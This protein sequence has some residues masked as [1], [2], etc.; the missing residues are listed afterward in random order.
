MHCAA[1]KTNSLAMIA[2]PQINIDSPCVRLFIEQWYGAK[3]SPAS[4]PPTIRAE[5]IK[6]FIKKL[7]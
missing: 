5:T 4:C 3:L 2:Q 7:N 1:V 6:I